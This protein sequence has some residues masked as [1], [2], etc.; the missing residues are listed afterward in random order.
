[1]RGRSL[2]L[3]LSQTLLVCLA[4][5]AFSLSL[6]HTLHSFSSL[7]PLSLLFSLTLLSQSLCFFRRF[8]PNTPLS[9]SRSLSLS[10]S[11]IKHSLIL[12]ETK[13]EREIL[14]AKNYDQMTDCRSRHETTKMFHFVS[15]RSL[16]QRLPHNG[17][18]LW[19]SWQSGCFRYQRSELRI[20][21]CQ[22]FI[23]NK[24]AVSWSLL[25]RLNCLKDQ[26]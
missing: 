5:S 26:N 19:L 3:S 22:N 25:K 23:M 21:D 12:L 7:T 14:A 10:L 20:H 9:L 2:S 6:E 1:M 8:L 11:L 24:S 17:Q 13:G 16:H 15:R 4:V 18:W